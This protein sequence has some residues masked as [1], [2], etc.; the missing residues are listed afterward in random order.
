MDT[1]H[2][3]LIQNPTIKKNQEESIEISS[4]GYGLESVQ[5][6]TKK[7]RDQSKKNGTNQS[8]GGL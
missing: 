1:N 6:E 3:D 4:T 7:V 2:F 5:K 8:C